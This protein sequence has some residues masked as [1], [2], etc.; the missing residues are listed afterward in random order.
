M[1]CHAFLIPISPGA[2]FRY[3]RAPVPLGWRETFSEF[4]HSPSPPL[5]Q[6]VKFNSKRLQK[7]I[8][9]LRIEALEPLGRLKIGV[10]LSFSTLAPHLRHFKLL[11]QI[12]IMVRV[13]APGV[14]YPNP[15]PSGRGTGGNQE[16]FS[17]SE[18]RFHKSFPPGLLIKCSASTKKSDV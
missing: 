12:L 4:K 11:L 8:Y 3:S 18:V 13:D 17:K 6:S 14:W 7:E 10:K 2:D 9:I 15:L 5:T 1:I 16:R